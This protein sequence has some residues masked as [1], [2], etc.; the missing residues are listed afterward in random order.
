MTSVGTTSGSATSLK[1]SPYAHVHVACAHGS[2]H[3]GH[4]FLI[5]F[6][7]TLTVARG[8]CIVCCLWERSALPRA[9]TSYGHPPTMAHAWTCSRPVWRSWVR[10]PGPT[11]RAP[12]SAAHPWLRRT[13]RALSPFCAQCMLMLHPE[14]QRASNLTSPSVSSLKGHD[15]S[16]SREQAPAPKRVGSDR[17]HHVRSNGGGYRRP[18]GHVRTA[19]THTQSAP[20]GRRRSRSGLQ[21]RMP[22]PAGSPC[23]ALAATAT[24]LLAV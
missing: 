9:M 18:P 21:S 24:A 17:C 19:G 2:S 3:S 15:S 11:R 12:T 20:L 16:P 14:P 4:T 1:S 7:H 8:V 10:P 22:L 5:P 6:A 23:A 13:S